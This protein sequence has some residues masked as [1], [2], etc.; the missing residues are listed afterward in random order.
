MF[1]ILYALFCGGIYTIGKIRDGVEDSQWKSF[2]INEK[3]QGKNRANLYRDHRG[4]Y[5]DLATGQPRIQFVNEYG[6]AC[7]SDTNGNTVRN[8]KRERIDD[9][10]RQ[11]CNETKGNPKAV[12]YEYWDKKNSRL[13]KDGE[14]CG[15]VYK[16]VETGELYFIRL[17]R[18]NLDDKA[19]NYC[20]QGD[21]H[22]TAC[23]GFYM[24]VSDATLAGTIAGWEDHISAPDVKPT[25]EQILE[26]MDFFNRKQIECKGGWL[27]SYSRYPTEEFDLY[28]YT[29]G[30]PYQYIWADR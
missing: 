30:N 1:G 19:I 21:R 10:W 4:V 7:L 17:I 3:K 23:A 26:F 22:H 25:N 16:D 5:R 27:G 9:E 13:R 15:R 2:A 6:E 29:S 18:W 11:R 14:I 12:F 20:S 24:R 8:L 28:M